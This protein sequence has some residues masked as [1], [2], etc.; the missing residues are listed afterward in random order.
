M[1]PHKFT[2]EIKMKAL[3][4]GLL[5]HTETS[6][7]FCRPPG[8]FSFFFLSLAAEVIL[9]ISWTSAPVLARKKSSELVSHL[10]RQE[11]IS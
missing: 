4:F 9:Q 2:G 6:F 1:K 3:A 5:D 8:S 7:S 10:A 11:S